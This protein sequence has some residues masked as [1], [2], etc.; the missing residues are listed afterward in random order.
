MFSQMS[1]STSNS[2][3][4]SVITPITPPSS[5]IYSMVPSVPLTQRFSLSFLIKIICAPGFRCSSIGV[6]N[7]LSGKLPLISPLNMLTS[8]SS[9]SSC[10]SLMKS[11]VSL[12]AARVMESGEPD[13]LEVLDKREL[14]DKLD[15]FA[16]LLFSDCR[17]AWVAVLLRMRSRMAINLSSV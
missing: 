13:E 5:S 11:T 4:S 15:G 12:R 9:A 14:L 16:T 10:W 3:L 1:R 8:P 17:S 7:E 6:G 2:S